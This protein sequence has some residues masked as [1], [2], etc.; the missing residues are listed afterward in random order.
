MTYNG[1]KYKCYTYF[2][3]DNGVWGFH[4]KDVHDEW[5]NNQ[6]KKSSIKFAN[7]DINVIMTTSEKSLEEQEKGGDDSQEN[8]LISMSRFE[9]L[10]WIVRSV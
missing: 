3:N 8:D 4:W 9:L 10:E 1:K 7:P 6:C 2:N 5:R